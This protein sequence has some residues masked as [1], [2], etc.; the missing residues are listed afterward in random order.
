[1]P[2]LGRSPGEG[3]GSPFQCSCLENP[4][5]RGA[6]RARVGHSRMTD[7]DTHARE[8]QGAR[9]QVWACRIAWELYF[10]FSKEPACCHP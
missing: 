6:W 7:P 9:A 1:M 3:N 2:K 4:V 5:D 10:L 8:H